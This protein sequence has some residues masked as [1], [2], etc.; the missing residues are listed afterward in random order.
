MKA[1]TLKSIF[2]K[3]NLDEYSVSTLLWESAQED[4]AEHFIA[5]LDG[6]L[7][8]IIDI[9]DLDTANAGFCE[10]DVISIQI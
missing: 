6:S 5:I 3:Y 7:L 2:Q 9:H 8:Y 10:G 1:A 4:D